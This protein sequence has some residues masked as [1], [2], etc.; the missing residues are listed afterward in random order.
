MQPPA[1]LRAS[2]GTRVVAIV[3]VVS[4]FDQS[5]MPTE[6]FGGRLYTFYSLG[7]QQRKLPT[8][9]F[10]RRVGSQPPSE[11]LESIPRRAERV[12]AATRRVSCR[13]QRGIGLD[14]VPRRC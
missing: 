7:L 11:E 8:W 13:V 6:N 5:C 12:T 10:S 2:R 14:A 3:H 9:L 4:N 1:S